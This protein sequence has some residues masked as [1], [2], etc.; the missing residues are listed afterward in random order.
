MRISEIPELVA[1]T[2]CQFVLY[3]EFY[4]EA[5]C[6]G[7]SGIAIYHEG[8]E[9]DYFQNFSI[10]SQDEFLAAVKSYIIGIHEQD[11]LDNSNEVT[12]G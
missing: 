11:E 2:G 4:F 6:Y 3:G 10:Q 9:V 7:G 5:R 1:Y 8:Q 12:Q